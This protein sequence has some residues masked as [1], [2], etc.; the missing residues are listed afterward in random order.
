MSNTLNNF[1]P[2]ALRENWV[3]N[4]WRPT[5]GW[6]YMTVCICDFIIFPAFWTIVQM[7]AGGD[8]TSQWIPIT[9]HGAGFFHIAMGAVLGIAVYGRTQE[10]INSSQS[11]NNVNYQSQYTGGD[12]WSNSNR[13]IERPRPGA[14]P[15][16]PDYPVRD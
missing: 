15:P 4:K 14:R 9:L 3:N 12:S 2:P 16:Q 5:M 7:E 10:K 8:V 1:E 13:N 11:F 6:M